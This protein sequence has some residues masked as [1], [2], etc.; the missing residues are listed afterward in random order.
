M[1]TVARR[2]ACLAALLF[3][4]TAAVAQ[5]GQ[6]DVVYVPTPQ[7]VVEAMLRMAKVGPADT[8]VDLGSGDGRVIITAAKLHG[9]RGLGV[10][11]D[12]YLLEVASE[13]ARKAGVA[14]RARFLEQDLF[15]IDLS[16][17]T[18]ITTY[19]LPEMNHRLQPKFLALSPGTRIVAHDYDFD[20]NWT[21]DA[22]EV[23]DVPG[24]TV[25]EPGKSHLFLYI[26]PAK[27]AGEWRSE[28]RH[29]RLAVPYEFSFEQEFQF[30][31]GR[32]RAG[33]Q[34]TAIPEF[35]LAGD[36]LDFTVRLTVEGRVLEH[37]FSGQVKS[38]LIEGTLVTGQ[39]AARR[40][41]PWRARLTRAGEISDGA[42]RP[43]RRYRHLKQ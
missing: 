28:V 26:V 1:N 35:K 13:N 41:Q 18:V 29:G 40:E 8:V 17:A 25:G 32:A 6:G 2:V 20:S 27:L 22:R 3:S 21:P 42:N 34:V 19:L 12:R 14:D 5:E 39:G 33:G 9:A 23:W 37:R 16:A 7:H 11:L 24:K 43:P 31:E 38:G 4:A 30:V 10:D 36:W 15:E